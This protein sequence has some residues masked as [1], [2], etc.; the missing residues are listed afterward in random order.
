VNQIKQAAGKLNPSC[1]YKQI[2]KN[3]SMDIHSFMQ[4][5]NIGITIINKYPRIQG[6][7]SVVWRCWE[8]AVKLELKWSL[9]FVILPDTKELQPSTMH[10]GIVEGFTAAHVYI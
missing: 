6:L 4:K 7:G 8:C 3:N 2:K 1:Q 9:N 5:H 10:D